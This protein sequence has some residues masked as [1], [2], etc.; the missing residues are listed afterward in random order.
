MAMRTVD[1]SVKLTV[2]SMELNSAVLLGMKLD[3][4]K[5]GEL[6]MRLAS[7]MG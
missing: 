4:W 7:Q 1:L 5:V 3:I 2:Y 6:A